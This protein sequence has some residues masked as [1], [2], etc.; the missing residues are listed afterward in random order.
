MT[1]RIRSNGWAPLTDIGLFATSHSLIAADYRDD[2][3]D[4]SYYEGSKLTAPNIN[5]ASSQTVDGEE[6]VKITVRNRY[7]LVYKKDLPGGGN[8]DVR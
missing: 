5:E 3:A 2:A 8:L 6:V 7:N 1:R 4:S